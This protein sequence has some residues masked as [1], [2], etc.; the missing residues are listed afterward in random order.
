[1][2]DCN[3]GTIV[4]HFSYETTTVCTEGRLPHILGSHA[5]PFI[6][7][8]NGPWDRCSH[9]SELNYV[10][11]LCLLLNMHSFKSFAHSFAARY[12]FGQLQLNFI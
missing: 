5:T 10:S 8:E 2:L 7:V 3:D 12:N 11:A 1:M 6:G 9:P 4:R